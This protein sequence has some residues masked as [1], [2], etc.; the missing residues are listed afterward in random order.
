M[1][2]SKNKVDDVAK[3]LENKI[4]DVVEKIE[5]NV[6]EDLVTNTRKNSDNVL[7]DIVD[8]PF[9]NKVDTPFSDKVDDVVDDFAT[10]RNNYSHNNFGSESVIDDVS[11]MYP[12]HT[13]PEAPSL[14][15][16]EVAHMPPYSSS[17]GVDDF[18]SPTINPMG[19]L[20]DMY[21]PSYDLGDYDVGGGFLDDLSD[22][23]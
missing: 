9:N 23:F 14:Y 3:S 22:M 15:E 17:F 7:S 6:A 10:S 8:S 19:G 16:A 13:M 2:Q 4:D 5:D 18:N 21:S 20:D 12:N 1:K 11:D